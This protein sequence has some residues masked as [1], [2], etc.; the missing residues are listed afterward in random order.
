MDG[1]DGA[2]LK[3]LFYI[4]GDR[5]FD[6]SVGISGEGKTPMSLEDAMESVRDLVEDGGGEM[7]II[8]CRV[9]RRIVRGRVR[10]ETIEQS[11]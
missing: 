7:Y 9:I 10:I 4:S 1:L 11:K 6:N 8:E 2:P 5:N 3:K